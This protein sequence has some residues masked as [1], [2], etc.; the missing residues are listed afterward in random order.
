MIENKVIFKTVSDKINYDD[1]IGLVKEY[2]KAYDLFIENKTYFN[3]FYDKNIQFNIYLNKDAELTLQNSNGNCIF[4]TINSQIKTNNIFTKFLSKKINKERFIEDLKKL[5]DRY[6]NNEILKIKK[7]MLLYKCSRLRFIVHNK[8]SL[9]HLLD[10]D[11]FI[12]LINEEY[13]YLTSYMKEFIFYHKQHYKTSFIIKLNHCITLDYTKNYF[14]NNKELT[15]NHKDTLYFKNI[16]RNLFYYMENKYILP[17]NIYLILIYGLYFKLFNKKELQIIE[18]FFNTTYQL[19][20]YSDYDKLLDF[21]PV[22]VCSLLSK[23]NIKITLE[24]VKCYTNIIWYNKLKSINFYAEY[25]KLEYL[26]YLINDLMT[27]D[28]ILITVDD[29]CLSIKDAILDNI[30]FLSNKLNVNEDTILSRLN[31]LKCCEIY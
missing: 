24:K 30:D 26:L 29:L 4:F 21:D 3:M 9:I 31:D 11:F 22:F 27:V 12:N 10:E 1:F 20:F 8:N 13:Q 17:N 28:F 16:K 6:K 15:H 5:I 14:N 19:Y 18:H 2:Q 23:N 25:Q 7:S